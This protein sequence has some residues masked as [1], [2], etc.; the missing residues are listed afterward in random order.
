MKHFKFHSNGFDTGT[1][2]PYLLDGDADPQ[3]GWVAALRWYRRVARRDP[4]ARLGLQMKVTLPTTGSVSPR[5]PTMGQ[6]LGL[7]ELEDGVYGAVSRYTV[8]SVVMVV[9]EHPEW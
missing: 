3:L 5:L 7:V 6:L 8:G 9:V 4:T 1:L 2:E